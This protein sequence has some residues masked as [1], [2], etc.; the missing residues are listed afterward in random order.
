MARDPELHQRFVDKV[1]TYFN[2]L[3]CI[4]EFGVKKNTTAWC[5]AKTADT[6]LLKPR[7]V[8]DYI[9]KAA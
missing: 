6:F 5:I 1:S 3:D 7:T 2:N 4:R 9:Y 8:E